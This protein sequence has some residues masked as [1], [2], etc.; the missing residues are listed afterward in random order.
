MYLFANLSSDTP[1]PPWTTEKYF[2]QPHRPLAPAE[3]SS[4]PD[5]FFEL[6]TRGFGAHANCT[7]VVELPPPDRQN[8]AAC[9]NA[10]S[11]ALDGFLEGL[12]YGGQRTSSVP[13]PTTFATTII[14]SAFGVLS[15][16]AWGGNETCGFDFY[17]G[18]GT[19]PPGAK[20]SMDHMPSL[21]TAAYCKPFFETAMF[22]VTVDAVGNIQSYHESADTGVG[23]A[24]LSYDTLT[25]KLLRYAMTSLETTEPSSYEPVDWLTAMMKAQESSLHLMDEKQLP[26]DPAAFIPVLEGIFARGFAIFL[27]HRQDLFDV[28]RVGDSLTGVKLTK[29]IRILLDKPSLAI[30]QTILAI[31]VAVAIIL[32]A[33]PAIKILPRMP[34]CIAS[35]IAYVASSRLVADPDKHISETSTFSFGRYIGLD[36]EQHIGIEIDPYVTLISKQTS[37][38]K[39]RITA[40]FNKTWGLRRRRGSGRPSDEDPKL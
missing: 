31:N 1:L 35:A 27:A 22:N 14:D 40:I 11:A 8:S 39:G 19:I 20:Y 34:T 12:R 4:S 17:V 38:G 6:R 10:T 28:A 2:L 36:G 16:A 13:I 26:P 5:T 30:T 7:P 37:T 21:V 18:W 33:R 24:D 3:A 23:F 25:P 9:T 29:E 15:T 32:Y